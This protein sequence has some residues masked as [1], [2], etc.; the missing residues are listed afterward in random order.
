MRI[1]PNAVFISTTTLVGLSTVV[2]PY[3]T[4]YGTNLFQI[5]T[6][7]AWVFVNRLGRLA[8]EHEFEGKPQGQTTVF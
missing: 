8:M 7:G 2:L 4:G 5:V 6:L 3:I 1:T